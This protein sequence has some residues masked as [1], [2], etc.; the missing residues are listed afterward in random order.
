[1][2]NQNLRVTSETKNELKKL[3]LKYAC[4]SYEKVILH[5]LDLES[6]LVLLNK[7]LK[8]YKL[9]SVVKSRIGSIVQ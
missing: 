5:L 2:D 9:K 7:E 4:G 3:K 1:M 8:Y 6:E